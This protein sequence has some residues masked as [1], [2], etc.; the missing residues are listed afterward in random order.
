MHW[1]RPPG[2]SGNRPLFLTNTFWKP[3]GMCSLVFKKRH[4]FCR[5]RIC[6]FGLS[7]TRNIPR[8][9]AGR[10]MG[11]CK[12]GLL[13]TTRQRWGV[14][15]GGWVPP[16]L[17]DWAIF[18]FGPQ[19]FSL[20]PSAPIGFD[21]KV[22]SA[23]LAPLTTQ[24]LFG[25]GGVGRGGGGWNAETTPAGAPAAAADRTQRPNA[26]CEGKNG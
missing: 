24:H 22:S 2:N 16:P 9:P 25:G 26:T 8:P 12:P 11:A 23:P 5:G 3:G 20:A 7:S 15:G 18:C 19:R 17:K 14:W 1:E 4:G 6:T 13:L 21:Q 10:C